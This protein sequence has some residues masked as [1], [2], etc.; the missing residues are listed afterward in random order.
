MLA[1]DNIKAEKETE[2]IE[3]KFND[4][5]IAKTV[6]KESKAHADKMN[7]YQASLEKDEGTQ[8]LEEPV[9]LL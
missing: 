7:E 3:R 5:Q 6:E 1:R 9:T 2:R 4:I 8:D